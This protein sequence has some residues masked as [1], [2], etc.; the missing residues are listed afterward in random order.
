MLKAW[1]LFTETLLLSPVQHFFTFILKIHIWKKMGKEGHYLI[2]SIHNH[3]IQDLW[4]HENKRSKFQSYED[5]LKVSVVLNWKEL[6]PCM[7]EYKYVIHDV[8]C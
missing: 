6:F 2:L 8:M 4:P 7:V 1:K 3:V 5:R